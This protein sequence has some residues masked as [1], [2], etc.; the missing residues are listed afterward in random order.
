MLTGKGPTNDMF[1]NGL[2]LHNVAKM[3]IPDGI[4]DISDPLL[5]Q[6]DEEEEKTTKDFQFRKQEK[7]EKVKQCLLSVF[8][9]GIACS[10]ELPRER[11]DISSVSEDGPKPDTVTW[12]TMICGYCSLQMLSEA[13]QLYEEL[14]HG[15]TK[16]NAI[17]YT[18]LINA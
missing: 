3:A 14:Q 7:D 15:R 10:M 5:F 4:M 9:V 11:I 16:P 2:N 6:H 12:N 18:I 8:R 1:N 13:L 17:T